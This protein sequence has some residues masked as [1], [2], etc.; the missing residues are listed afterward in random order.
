M[1]F[2][3]FIA[4]LLLFSALFLALMLRSQSQHLTHA[5]HRLDASDQIILGQRRKIKEL[6]ESLNHADIVTISQRNKIAEIHEKLTR[7][8]SELESEL[9]PKK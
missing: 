8:I 5:Q 6:A 1:T 2:L 9:A 3:P 7:R 4:M